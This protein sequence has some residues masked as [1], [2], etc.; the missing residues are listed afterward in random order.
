MSSAWP[1]LSELLVD[2]AGV[3]IGLVGAR[4][5]SFEEQVRLMRGARQVVA[6]AGSA[7]LMTLFAP[8]GLRSILMTPHWVEVG[9]LM[10][11]SRALDH[12]IT[13]LL[14]R[15]VRPHPEYSWQSDYEIDP[16][17]LSEVLA[18]APSRAAADDEPP[19]SDHGA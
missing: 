7:A 19:P 1:N 4:L 5:L 9:F 17:A 10:H 16:A 2:D 15:I 13:V 18:E 6:A 8:P 14:G 11:T 12:E 3:P